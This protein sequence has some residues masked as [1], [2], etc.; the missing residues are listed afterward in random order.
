MENNLPTLEGNRI[1]L[2][3]FEDGDIPHTLELLA[4]EGVRKYWGVFD[5]ARLRREF[6][7]YPASSV[8]VIEHGGESVGSIHFHEETDPDYKRA[9]MDIFLATSFQDRGL[10]P[11]A[12]HTLSCYLFEERGH[13]AIDITPDV[14]NERAIAAYKKVGFK[15]VGVR[16][17]FER[18]TDGEWH[19]SLLM[20]M[21][22]EELTE[23]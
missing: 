3:P 19:D 23:R 13:H 1:S 22:A 16:R 17:L 14:A 11:D 8:F 21:L 9:S 7:G 18:G 2:R 6:F 12:L 20:D 4:E 5:E 10:G 15:P